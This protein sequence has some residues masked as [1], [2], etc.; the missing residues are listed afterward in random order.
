[1]SAARR[2]LAPQVVQTSAM[3]CGPAALASLLQGFGVQASYGRL[4]EACQTDVDGTSIDTLEDIAGSLGLDAEQTLAPVDHLLAVEADALPAVVVVRLPNGFTHFVVAWRTVGRRVLLMDPATGRRWVPAAEFLRDLYVHEMAVPASAFTEWAISEQFLGPLRRRLADIGCGRELEPQIAEA[5]AEGGWR[6]IAGIDAA[7][8]ITAAAVRAGGLVR[9]REAAAAIR[10]QW[11]LARANPQAIPAAYWTA[12]A[13]PP[14]EDGGEQ[15]RLRGAVA[16]SVHGRRARQADAPPLSPELAAALEEPPVR[17]LRELAR[18]A[19]E[20]WSGVLI[21]VVLAIAVVAATAGTVLEAL[22]LRG[23]MSVGRDLGVTQQRLGGTLAVLAILALLLLLEIP[24]ARGTVR[25]GRAVELRLRVLFLRKIP[26][27]GDRYFATRP[28]SDMA[29]RVHAIHGVRA[30]PEL[31]VQLGR[32]VFEILL[33]AAGIVWLDPA[34]APLAIATAI[35]VIAVPLASLPT[36]A[37]RDLRLRTHAGS[38]GRFYLDAM[39][40]LSAIWSHGAE[41]SVRR[42]QESLLVEWVRAAKDVARAYVRANLVQAV[43]GAALSAWLL[44]RY[45]AGGGEPS[46]VLLLVYW[47]L[48]LPVLGQDLVALIRQ[49]PQ[50]RTAALRLLEPLG[51]REEPGDQCTPTRR[52]RARAREGRV[53]GLRG[54]LGGR[55]RTHHP[56][57][58]R[59]LHR[60]GVARRRRR[61]IGRGQVEPP[62]AAPRVAPPSVGHGAG[63]RRAGGCQAA[64]GVRVGQSLGDVVEPERRREHPLRRSGRLPTP[65]GQRR[66]SVRPAGGAGE[67]AGGPPDAPR[68]RWRA[69]VRW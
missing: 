38:L 64:R 54:G 2:F 56:R 20:G 12:S 37:E 25:V 34:S 44:A 24:T 51:A 65:R 42:E 58:P 15:V 7:T 59:A 14:G 8:R 28:V 68:R 52:R 55:R 47:A 41:P 49:Y 53:A 33:T 13:A 50:H 29:E 61:R 1:M 11:A 10:A 67:A 23:I 18:V 66:R 69:G 21:A 48:N 19:L 35:L 62:R 40:G 31:A 4:R 63:R 60:A 22:L 30:L 57:R 6:P 16:L 26:R 27:L 43:A 9:G 36:L 5:L 17:P 46:G 45:V 32:N 3:D 39:L